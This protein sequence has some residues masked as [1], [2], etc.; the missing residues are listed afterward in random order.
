LL[1]T[2]PARP[3]PESGQTRPRAGREPGRAGQ[4]PDPEPPSRPEIH[5]PPKG[6]WR[7]LGVPF[8]KV[9][10]AQTPPLGRKGA[11]EERERERGAMGALSQFCGEP[12]SDYAPEAGHTPH[13][14]HHSP[15]TAH[16][17]HA[18]TTPQTQTHSNTP[19]TTNRHRHHHHNNHSLPRTTHHHTPTHHERFCVQGSAERA[20]PL[21]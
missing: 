7:V 19:N 13:T 5:R 6:S 10:F 14:T 1:L 12:P 4:E 9:S 8:P 2:L 18:R 20:K 15:H 16:T 21:V 11:R 17:T 3:G